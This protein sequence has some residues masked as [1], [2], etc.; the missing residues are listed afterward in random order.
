MLTYNFK[1]N[2]SEVTYFYIFMAF[3][4][5]LSLILIIHMWLRRKGGLFWKLFWTV[6]LLAPYIGPIVYFALYN[7]PS[8]K[9]K[10]EQYTDDKVSPLGKGY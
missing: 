7:P 2:S 4:L 5:C 1:N 9:S 6:F 8:Q 3:S 10:D